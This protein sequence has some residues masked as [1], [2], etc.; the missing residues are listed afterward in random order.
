MAQQMYTK[1]QKITSRNGEGSYC[2]IIFAVKTET[3]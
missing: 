1:I 3:E 2:G